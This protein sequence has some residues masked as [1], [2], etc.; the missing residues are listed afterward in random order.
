MPLGLLDI[1]IITNKLTGLLDAACIS[2]PVRTAVPF[3]ISVTGMAPD[4]IRDNGDGNCQLS[5]YLFHVAADRFQRNSPVT[6]PVLPNL[7]C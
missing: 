6:N 7:L 1:S 2:S 5:L 4:A 3:D